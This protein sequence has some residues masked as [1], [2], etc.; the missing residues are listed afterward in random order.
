M[1]NEQPELAG[2]VDVESGLLGAIIL[3]TS[4]AF[5]P[6]GVELQGDYV[7]WWP[8]DVERDYLEWWGYDAGSANPYGRETSP[9]GMLDAFVQ[10]KTPDAALRFARRYGPL[11]LCEHGLPTTHNWTPE[12]QGCYPVG[13][14]QGVCR[15]PLERWLYYVDQARALVAIAAALQRDEK[16][17]EEAWQVLLKR[18]EGD[19]VALTLAVRQ[20]ASLEGRRS[21]LGGLVNE[22]L[23]LA[24][25]RLSVTW[26][27][28]KAKWELMMRGT[29]FGLLAMQLMFAIA[30][31]HRLAICDGCQRPYLR[32][33]RVPQSGRRNFCPDCG[34]TVAARLRQRERRARPGKGG[35]THEQTSEQ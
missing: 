30:G 32:E 28:T 17:L 23:V 13:W 22:W 33:G 11:A 16:E 35:I 3:P 12:R 18:Y 21:L 6:P 5:V 15:E 14:E 8:Y 34:P 10:M 2:M 24:N 4:Q 20:K 27:A 25:A 29:T 7:V 31:Q 19:D 1:M 26:D 9:R